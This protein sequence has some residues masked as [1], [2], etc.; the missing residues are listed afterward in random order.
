MKYY[1][2]ENDLSREGFTSKDDSVMGQ[3]NHS[4]VTFLTVLEYFQI[5]LWLMSLHFQ[6]LSTI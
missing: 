3:K 6:I 5:L 4:E 1:R 2:L